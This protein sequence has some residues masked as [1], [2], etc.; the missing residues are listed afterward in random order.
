MFGKLI[1]LPIRIANI[2]FRAIEMLIGE[3]P[4]EERIASKPL[5]SIAKAIEEALDGEKD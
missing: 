3:I 4:K 1:S 2:P 5:D